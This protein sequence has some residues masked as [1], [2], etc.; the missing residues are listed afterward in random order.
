MREERE[1]KPARRRRIPRPLWALLGV[2]A[3]G[4]TATVLSSRRIAPLEDWSDLLDD[5]PETERRR[6]FPSTSVRVAGPAGDLHVDDGGDGGAGALPVVLVHGLGGAAGQWAPQLDHLRAGRRALALDLRGHGRSAPSA[7]GS[8]G[9][10]AFADDL[11]AVVD[12]L[13]IERF[14]LG[15][16]SL[17]ASVAIAFAER[18]PQRVAALLLADP[19][20]DQTEIP[21]RELDAF[22]AALERDPA[23]EM[24]SYFK[25]ILVGAEPAVAERV[26]ADLGAVPPEVFAASL[27]DSFGYSPAAGLRRFSGPRLAVISDLNSLP[28]SLHNLVADLPVELLPGTSH[29][30][31]LDRPDDFN[32]LLDRLLAA[33]G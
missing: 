17:G 32:R 1:E 8:Y 20:G 12:E 14:V 7:D 30:Q 10:A 16:H 15:G 4:V 3:L 6:L 24:R 33:A 25:Q 23:A 31:M 27:R 5:E 19:N 13:G 18:H 21:R 9:V 22:L 26:L 2:A 29:W 11:G 28:Y